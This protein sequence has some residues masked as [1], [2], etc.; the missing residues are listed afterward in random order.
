[1]DIEKELKFLKWIDSLIREDKACPVVPEVT[2]A[3]T[4]D[5]VRHVDIKPVDVSKKGE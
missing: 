1:M 2:G 4:I 5:G 3:K